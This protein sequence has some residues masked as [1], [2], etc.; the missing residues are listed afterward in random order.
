MSS[1]EVFA[2]F[3]NLL[4]DDPGTRQRIARS[5]S[6]L[7]DH[8]YHLLQEIG[9]DCVGALQFMSGEDHPGPPGAVNGELITDEQIAEKI[10]NLYTDPLGLSE[11]GEFRISIAGAQAKS[12]LLNWDEK[13]HIPKS[14]TATTHIL[15][16]A[17]GKLPDGLDLSDS[18]EN[19]HLC[20]T[21]VGELGIEAAETKIQNFVDQHV[22]VVK[23]FDRHWT[24]DHRLLR[25][26]QEDCCQ[27]L[28]VPSLRKYQSNGGPSIV[29]IMELLKSADKPMEE[30]RLFLKSQVVLWL[31]AAIDGHGK[32]FSIFLTP[33]G[34]FALTPLYDVM[35]VQSYL[36]AREI[37]RNQTKMAMSIGTS[38]HYRL[39]TIRPYH[40]KQTAAETGFPK[41]MFQ[42]ILEE[43]VE[44][45]PLAIE[46]VGASLP[47]G[48]PQ[49]LFAAITD[50]IKTRLKLCEKEA[51]D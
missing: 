3:E 46:T 14:S 18:V 5:V 17:I 48:F 23:R 41:R 34:G 8:P 20:M 19:E 45:C 47:S 21:L 30:R 35:S 7:S 39:H 49:N 28:G 33:G 44:S 11:D 26:A 42:E 27:A 16:P 36:N 43:L 2:V 22:L 13:W 29:Q 31:L 32:N 51:I 4:P 9:R 38:N 6:A 24:S 25:L 40:F 50:G 1:P 37:P 12:A 10:R 15:K